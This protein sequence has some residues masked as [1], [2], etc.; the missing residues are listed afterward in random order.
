VTAIA[1]RLNVAVV[2]LVLNAPVLVYG[3]ASGNRI[4]SGIATGVAFTAL[5]LL[6][7]NRYAIRR[8]RKE[9]PR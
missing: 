3:I 5:A 4:A 1:V 7:Y 8:V 2:L 9:T 6:T